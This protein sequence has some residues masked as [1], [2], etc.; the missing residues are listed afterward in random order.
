MKSVIEK[1]GHQKM[2]KLQEQI[3]NQ[4]KTISKFEADIVLKEEMCSDRSPK[5]FLHSCLSPTS[6]AYPSACSILGVASCK[7]FSFTNSP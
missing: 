2:C 3:R 5:F 1:D 6:F 7:L 4:E